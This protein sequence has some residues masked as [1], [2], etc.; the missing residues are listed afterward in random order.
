M[1]ACIICRFAIEIDDV[2]VRGARGHRV[3]CL[4]CYARE[5]GTHRAMPKSLRREIQAALAG[6]STT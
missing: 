3:V 5:T 1:T 4:R 6:I 2:A